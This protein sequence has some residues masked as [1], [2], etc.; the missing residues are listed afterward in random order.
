MMLKEPASQHF[1]GYLPLKADQHPPPA[2]SLDLEGGVA[3]ISRPNVKAGWCSRHGS[4]YLSRRC[5]IDVVMSSYGQVSLRGVV[6]Q[7]P[8]TSRRI[9]NFNPSN[10]HNAC[11]HTG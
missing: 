4:R 8:S 11:K 1:A 6:T 10:L 7:H 2:Y 9:H 5:S 3:V